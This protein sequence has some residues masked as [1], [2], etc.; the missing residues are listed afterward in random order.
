M[1]LEFGT[2][3]RFAR[4]RK[5][6]AKELINFA[7]ESGIKSFDCGVNYGNWKSQPLLGNILEKYLRKN[8]SD[9][10]I[11]SKAGTHSQG[12]TH[13]KIFEATYIEEMILK[14][15]YDLNC[16]FLD[17]FF[18]HGPTKKDLESPELIKKLINL[19]ENGLI[20]NIGINT[21][22]IDVMRYAN[23]FLSKDID[24]VLIDY[25]LIQNDREDIINE[26][27]SNN[28]SVKVGT[29][30][31]QGLLIN[32]PLEIVKRSL[33]PFYAARLV[34]SSNTRKLIKP[35]RII[36]NY[37]RD[38][39][40]EQRNAIPLSFV[41]NN[42]NVLKIP[43][44]MLSKESIVNNINIDKNPASKITTDSVLNWYKNERKNHYI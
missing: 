28:I 43:I 4:L 38:N 6:N 35:S 13:K 1:K 2:G 10:Q 12:L 29:A 32:S 41:L 27:Y 5:N 14:S 9:F 39:H 8:R 42:K 22:N 17:H 44:G 3:A 18:L 21:H 31:C 19:K 15:I 36:R 25:N 7:I 37:I 40:W 20:K 16:N 33:S 11:S 34:L 26:F 24:S 30:L 23:K